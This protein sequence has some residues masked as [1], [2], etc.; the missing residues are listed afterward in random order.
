MTKEDEVKKQLRWRLS[1]R[2]TVDNI[3][4]LLS[5]GIIDKT[6]AKQIALEE[7]EIKVKSLKDLESE[8]ALLREL[9]LELSKKQP[10]TIVKIIESYPPRSVPYPMPWMK[11]YSIFCSSTNL[12]TTGTISKINADTFDV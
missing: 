12:G 7:D 9:V 8:I 6:E 11:P 1:E 4:K 5:L 3:E 10:Q 2:P